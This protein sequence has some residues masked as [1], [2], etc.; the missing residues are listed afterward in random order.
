MERLKNLLTTVVTLG[1]TLLVMEIILVFQPVPD[2]LLLLPFDW[3]H[4]VLHFVP[5]REFTWS[6]GVRM[7]N[8]N[9]GHINNYGFVNNQEYAPNDNR[10]LLAVVGDS[11]V[12]AAIVPYAQTFHARLSQEAGPNRRVYSFGVSGN[13]LLDYLYNAE[14]ASREF[15]AR[16]FIVNVVNNDFDEM[17]LRYKQ[18]RGF[19][20]YQVLADGSLR[21]TLIEYHPGVS[22]TLIR[23]TAL[24]RYVAYSVFTVDV[25]LF[26]TRVVDRFWQAIR[27]FSVGMPVH[28]ESTRATD[29]DAERIELS[30]K[31]MRQVLTDFPTRLGVAPSRI[32][33]LVDGF[34]TVFDGPD[35]TKAENSYYGIMRRDFMLEARQRGFEVQDL[36]PW[37]ALRHAKDGSRFV[38]PDD[39][40]WNPVGHEEAFHAARSSHLW[41]QFLT[42]SPAV[43][44]SH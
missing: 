36:Q 8:A 42:Q 38:W 9:H 39:G 7:T 15:G 25:R 2:G 31:A 30:R 33:F 1:I 27:T 17:L 19:H 12:E 5:N 14:F 10:P 6:T 37:F 44:E 20:Y 28:A 4:P 23:S 21:E 29:G 16:Y 26:V 24:T 40:H 22:R 35:L 13:S 18:A 43:A 34:R 41:Q 11:F 32:L 3:A